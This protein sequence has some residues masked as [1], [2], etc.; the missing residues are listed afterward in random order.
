METFS[1]LTAGFNTRPFIREW[2]DS[3]LS[4]DYRPLEVVFVDDCSTDGTFDE[5]AALKG[6]FEDKDIVLK[7]LKNPCRSHYASTLKAAFRACSGFYV[8]VLDSDDRLVPHACEKIVP[9]YEGHP[10]VAW[11]YTAYLS[12]DSKMISGKRGLSAYPKFGSLLAD[13]QR[14]RHTYSHWRTFTRRVDKPEEIF[15]DGL[16]SAV[17][18]YMGYSLEEKAVGGFLDEVF[19]H[20]RYGLSTSITKTEKTIPSWKRIVKQF[21]DKRQKLGIVPHRIIKL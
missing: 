18:K 15:C 17:D 9:V 12:F 3:V 16:K 20:Y 1:L 6:E 13:G 2:A 19:Y 10:E 5:A 8:G 7:M 11:I 14:D 21:S 4:Q